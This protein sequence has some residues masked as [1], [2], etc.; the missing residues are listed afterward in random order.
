MQYCTR[1]LTAN[2]KLIKPLI[3]HRVIQIVHVVLTGVTN[4]KAGAGR[5]HRHMDVKH[6]FATTGVPHGLP[7]ILRFIGIGQLIVIVLLPR[8][9]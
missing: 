9:T 4:H 1:I 7:L 6:I 3:T 5:K 2:Y 8:M